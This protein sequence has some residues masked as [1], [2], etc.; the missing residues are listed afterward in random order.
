MLSQVKIQQ[1]K[2]LIFEIEP[3][4]DTILDK[5]INMK[6]MLKIGLAQSP[7]SISNISVQMKEIKEKEELIYKEINKSIS[8]DINHEMSDIVLSGEEDNILKVN[9]NQSTLPNNE[10]SEF[11][12][13]DLDFIVS[14]DNDDTNIPMSYE[15]HTEDEYDHKI[16]VNVKMRDS[17]ILNI[18]LKNKE[19]INKMFERRINKQSNLKK[20]VANNKTQKIIKPKNNIMIKIKNIF[21]SFSG[22]FNKNKKV[23]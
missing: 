16:I 1:A 20:Q 18:S 23:N 5:V 14:N 22:I 3:D 21:K 11:T 15:N 4:I 7:E 6:N 13:K 10:E 17:R 2:N 8:S 12:E 19:Q 9:H